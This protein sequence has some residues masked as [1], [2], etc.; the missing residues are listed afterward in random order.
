MSESTA[1]WQI[2][3][4]VGEE[5]LKKLERMVIRDLQGLEAGLSGDDS[6]LANAWDEICVQLQQG[7]SIFWGAYEMTIAGL[8][9]RRVAGLK[10]YEVEAIWWLTP[11]AEEWVDD[12]DVEQRG[13][14]PGPCR[15]DVVRLVRDR[16]IG[17]AADWSN[18]RIRTWL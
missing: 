7:E 2:V 9:E 14:C 4:R 16:V 8:A 3:R 1:H 12:C 10:N 6:G 18:P 17:A 11:E 13:A 5:A 15:S